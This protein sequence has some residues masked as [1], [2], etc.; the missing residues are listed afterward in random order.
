MERDKLLYELTDIS[1]TLE[2]EMGGDIWDR[3]PKSMQLDMKE[4]IDNLRTSVYAAFGY[5]FIH[6]KN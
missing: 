5:A 4:A 6:P 2:Y 1:E 3:I